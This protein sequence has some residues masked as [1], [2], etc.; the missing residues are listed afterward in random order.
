M[1][2]HN[3]IQ[4]ILEAFDQLAATLLGRPATLARQ[5]VRIERQARCIAT[6]RDNRRP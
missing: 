1:A 2:A 3:L 4:R 6:P 5:P